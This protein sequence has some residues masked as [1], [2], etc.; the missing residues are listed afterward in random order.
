MGFDASSCKKK[1]DNAFLFE[2]GR[3]PYLTKVVVKMAHY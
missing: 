2:I 1:K 3:F